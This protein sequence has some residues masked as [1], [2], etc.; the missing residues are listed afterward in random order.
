MTVIDTAEGI[1]RFHFA[2]QRSALRLEIAGLRHSSRRSIYAHVKRVYGF[3][4]S[5]QSV[6]D[7]MQAMLDAGT[8]PESLLTSIKRSRGELPPERLVAVQ[9]PDGTWRY[10][11]ADGSPP[12]D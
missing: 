4:G 7:Q 1:A 9:A 3:K 12:S 5:R 6:L 11:P 2:S 10:F 8:V